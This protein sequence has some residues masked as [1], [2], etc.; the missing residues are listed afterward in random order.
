MTPE[1]YHRWSP[2]NFQSA[3]W[4]AAAE[5]YVELMEHMRKLELSHKDGDHQDFVR[6]EA[7]EEIAGLNQYH[8]QFAAHFAKTWARQLL[9]LHAIEA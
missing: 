9:E 1:L 4:Q 5:R 2:Y 6:C 3:D 7:C 8:D